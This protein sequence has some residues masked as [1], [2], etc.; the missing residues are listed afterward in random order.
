ME[1]NN[2]S[3]CGICGL[4]EWCGK[5]IV[6]FHV[7]WNASQVCANCRE[8]EKPLSD[9][10]ELSRL[11]NAVNELGDHI[12]IPDGVKVISIPATV[13]EYI[14]KLKNDTTRKD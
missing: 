3:K 2:N 5:P 12:G 6:L 7:N 13:I 10:Q 9:S 8:T 14:E 11:R 1:E 4:T